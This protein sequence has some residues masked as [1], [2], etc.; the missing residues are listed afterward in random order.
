MA[1]TMAP[2][3]IDLTR[4]SGGRRTVSTMSASLTASASVPTISAPEFLYSWSEKCERSPAPERISTFAP[5]LTSFFAVSGLNPMRGSSGP[6]AGTPMVIILAPSADSPCQMAGGGIAAFGGGLSRSD[7][8]HGHQRHEEGN[9]DDGAK[10]KR[11]KQSVGLSM[12]CVVHRRMAFGWVDMHSAPLMLFEAF[13]PIV[14]TI[15]AVARAM[16]GVPK[17]IL[18]A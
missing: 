13:I 10:R 14:D 7:H 2:P 18:P 16:R 4:S 8:E 3:F 5:S 9:A 6:S 17:T 11:E 12:L 15:K 1:I